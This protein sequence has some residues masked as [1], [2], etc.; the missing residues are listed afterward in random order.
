MSTAPFANRTPDA[1]AVVCFVLDVLCAWSVAENHRRGSWATPGNS[2]DRRQPGATG[3]ARRAGSG[4]Q[5]MVGARLAN[6]ASAFA[7]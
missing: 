6:L 2:A 3:G 1:P 5:R 4:R 7:V